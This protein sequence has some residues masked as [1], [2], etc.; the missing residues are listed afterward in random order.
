MCNVEQIIRYLSHF[1]I[2]NWLSKAL[3]NSL[4]LGNI[5]VKSSESDAIFFV[6]AKTL[7]ESLFKC[8][9]IHHIKEQY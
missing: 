5:Q 2:E 8:E 7:L 6:M 9:P 4:Y 3:T 1:F